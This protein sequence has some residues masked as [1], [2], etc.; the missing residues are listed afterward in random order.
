MHDQTDDVYKI[1]KEPD[2]I[3]LFPISVCFFPQYTVYAAFQTHLMSFQLYS[4]Y[5]CEHEAYFSCEK[6]LNKAAF[7]PLRR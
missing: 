3:F 5:L 6:S 7:L 4:P 2:Y 1:C